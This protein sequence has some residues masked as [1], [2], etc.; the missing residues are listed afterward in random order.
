MNSKSRILFA[1][2]LCLPLILL[3]SCKKEPT[4]LTASGRLVG[5]WKMIKFATDDNSNGLIEEWEFADVKPTLLSTLEFKADST[6]VEA[7][8]NIPDL[9]FKWLLT[10]EQTLRFIY[11]FGDTVTYSVTRSTTANLHLLAR[12]QYGLAAYQYESTK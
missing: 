6:G 8:T 11:S 10:S 2:V 4:F 7:N 9:R 3:F 1:S 12:T 5:K